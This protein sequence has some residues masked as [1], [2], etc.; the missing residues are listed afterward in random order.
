MDIQTLIA[1]TE[2][3][4]LRSF[5]DAAEKLHLTQPAISKRI[6][7]LESQLNCALFDRIGRQ[8]TLTEA[9]RALLPRASKILFEIEDAR[10]TLSNLTGVV[11]GKLSIGTSHHI[12]LHRLPPVLRTFSSE[13]PAVKLD[14]KFVDSEQACEAVQQGISELGIVTLPPI[15]PPNLK[16]ELIWR[17]PLVV[18]V[19]HEHPLSRQEN[20]HL[21][22]LAPFPAILSSPSTF[23]RRI[24]EKLFREHDLDVDVA[25]STNYLETI[26]MM[27]SIG[28]GWSVL[29]L[30][31]LDEDVR[32]LSIDALNI[33]RHL[34]VVYHPNHSLSNAAKVMLEILEEHAAR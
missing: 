24:V 33:E 26:K 6:A 27:V 22:D 12:G 7:L 3:A 18:F 21:S 4:E 34:G 17:D 28:L 10:R 8:V 29:P 19:G 32:H 16:A 9:G 25:I 15:T 31:M 11:A 23:T 20:I 1:F 13:H 14:I 2:I 30:S 5:S